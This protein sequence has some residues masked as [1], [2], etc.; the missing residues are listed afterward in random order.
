M[1]QSERVPARPYFNERK[2]T[3]LAAYL[4]SKTNRPYPHL[5]LIKLIYLIDRAAFDRRG[6]AVSTDIYF[7]LLHGPVVSAIMDLARGRVITN[8]G[9]W[10]K[11]IEPSGQ[12][13]I[14]LIEQ[15]DVDEL[16]E[17]EIALADEIFAEHGS[18]SWKQLRDESHNLPEYQVPDEDRYGDRRIPLSVDDILRA[19]GKSQKEINLTSRRLKG[20]AILDFLK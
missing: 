12:Y 16:S 17:F 5:S 14:K 4:L 3:Q 13:H 10:S 6:V 8:E 18:K 1:I 11:H 7:C 20:Q 15:T 19:L 9:I 2:A